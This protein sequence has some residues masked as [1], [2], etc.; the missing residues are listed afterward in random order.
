M[1][2]SL[3]GPDLVA[4]ALAAA[5]VPRPPQPISAIWISSLP[6]ACAARSAEST[7][8]A[9]AVLVPCLVVVLRQPT[10]NAMAE[11]ATEEVLINSRRVVGEFGEDSFI[12]H[13]PNLVWWL[14]I[15]DLDEAH[16]AEAK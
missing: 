14:S 11:A 5:P 7:A 13:N 16:H 9:A 12:S 8:A 15:L 3:I 2:T 1:A 6:A 4:S 10:P